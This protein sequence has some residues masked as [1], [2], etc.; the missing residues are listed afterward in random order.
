[1]ELIHNYNV[2]RERIINDPN[3]DVFINR[4]V[5]NI[6]VINLDK[7]RVRK[8]YMLMLLKKYSINFEFIVVTKL[9]A[10]QFVVVG[11]PSMTYGQVGCYLSHMYC[12]NDA[13]QQKYNNI[14]IFE[15]DIIFHKNF[16]TMFENIIRKKQYEVLMLGA[17][18]FDFYKLNYTINKEDGLTYQPK[19]NNKYL[20]GTFAIYYSNYGY[21]QFFNKKICELTPTIIDYNLAY[22]YNLILHN[23][24]VCYPNL[25]IADNSST[26]ICNTFGIQNKLRYKTYSKKCYNN[27]LIL[28]DYHIIT[29]AIIDEY[30][31][32]NTKYFRNIFESVVEQFRF[33]YKIN[34]DHKLIDES[35]T[36]NDMVLVINN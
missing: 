4:H 5:D 28:S 2:T 21:T 23:Y 7:D 25:I 35:F 15:D 20:Y 33:K 18:D 26:N 14:I 19:T 8:N 11:N 24:G 30:L 34:Y 36:E 27:K 10:D 3:K 22:M 17:S 32:T 12:L 6:Y 9:T 29:L 13:I 16:H 31:L 1:M